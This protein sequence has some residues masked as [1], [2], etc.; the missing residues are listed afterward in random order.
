MFRGRNYDVVRRDA[1][2][3]EKEQAVIDDLERKVKAL[4]LQLAEMHHQQEPHHGPSLQRLEEVTDTAA[5][6]Y[7]D[8]IV[9]NPITREYVFLQRY[10]GALDAKRSN[11]KFGFGYLH[12]TNEYKVVRIDCNRKT[13]HVYA[14]GSGVGWR[15]IKDEFLYIFEGLSI[16]ANGAI[17]WLESLKVW[18]NKIVAFDLTDEKFKSVPSPTWED[19][20][21]IRNLALLG[22]NLYVVFYYTRGYQGSLDIWALK[23]A[24]NGTKVLFPTVVAGQEYYDNMWSWNKEFSI[25]YESTESY[26]PFAVTESNEVLLWITKYTSDKSEPIYIYCYDPNNS[27]LNISSSAYY[28]NTWG[29]FPQVFPHMNALV[30]LKEIGE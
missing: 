25:P 6:R 16:F 12:S 20:Y 24:V 11:L 13:I 15:I 5:D 19:Y 29:S 1:L 22:G 28:R 17:H 2:S 18:E 23:K 7:E 26:K 9:C 30:S 14:L 8:F 10:D 3:D 27:T 4:T 21:D